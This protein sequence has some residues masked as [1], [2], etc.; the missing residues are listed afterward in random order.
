MMASRGMGDINPKKMPGKKTVRRKDDPDKVATYRDGGETK[1][2]LKPYVQGQITSDK[3][4]SG[5]IGRAH[6]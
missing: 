5:E 3:Y 4:G 1:D 6:V 2:E